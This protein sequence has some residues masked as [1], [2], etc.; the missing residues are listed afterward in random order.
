M[1]ICQQKAHYSTSRHFEARACRFF[2]PDQIWFILLGRPPF[3]AESRGWAVGNDPV[4]TLWYNKIMESTRMQSFWK[5]A[6]AVLAGLALFSLLGTVGHAGT[7][8]M[9]TGQV[10]L[11]IQ[12]DIVAKNQGDA[13]AFDREMLLAMP[14]I[15]FRTRTI[16]TDG[17]QEFSGV[18]LAA[19]ASKVGA[20]GTVLRAMAVNDYAVDIPIEALEEETPIV[21]LT[22]NGAAMTVRDKG[23]LWIVYPYDASPDYQNEV[24]YSRSIWQLVR[25]TSL[26]PP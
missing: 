11:T 21:A 17:V 9:P 12:G 19:I 23:P 24:V 1:I 13:A 2:F 6:R 20:K 14:Q 4:F 18:P 8:A 16:W 3:F 25:L 7:L 10:L 26:T 15:T 5:L 22:M